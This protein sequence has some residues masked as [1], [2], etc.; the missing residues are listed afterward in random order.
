MFSGRVIFG[1]G[2]FFLCFHFRPDHLTSFSVFLLSSHMACFTLTSSYIKRR[3]RTNDAVAFVI[4]RAL[5]LHV[6]SPLFEEIS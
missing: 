4:S 3:P 1:G 5:L 6:C 2:G